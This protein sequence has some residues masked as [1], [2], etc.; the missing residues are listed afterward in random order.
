MYYETFVPSAQ[1]LDLGHRKV[2]EEGNDDYFY[3]LFNQ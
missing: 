3:D 1:A 2:E